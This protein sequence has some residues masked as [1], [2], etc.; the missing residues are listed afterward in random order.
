VCG[1]PIEFVPKGAFHISVYV[2]V[3][4]LEVTCFF[5]FHGELNFDVNPNE[6][7]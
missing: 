4:K 6:V 3:Q 1:F 2:D 5:Y 7:V